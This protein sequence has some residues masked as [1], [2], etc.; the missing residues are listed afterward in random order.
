VELAAGRAP[1]VPNDLTT[2]ALLE[3]RGAFVTLKAAGRLRGCIGMVEAHAPLKSTVREM[4]RAAAVG[5]PR[6]NPLRAEE[7]DGVSIEISVLSPLR[8]LDSPE[9]IVVG[10]HGL[11]VEKGR[12][13]GLLLPQ[14]ASEAG[15]DAETFLSATCEKAGLPRSAW[16]DEDTR[17]YA[18]T[19][20]VFGEKKRGSP[21]KPASS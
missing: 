7:L 21:R 2:Q 4:A 3:R 15:W 9:D 5:D 1:G 14:V 8:L 19:A 20:F 13:R 10:V 6:F 12:R 18:F 11:V 16:R 17:I